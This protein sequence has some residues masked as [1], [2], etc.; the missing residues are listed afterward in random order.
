MENNIR[1]FLKWPGN[2]YHL[3]N[4]IKKYLKEPDDNTVFVEPFLGSAAVFLNT[5]Y[6]QYHLNDN[7]PDLINLYL[8]LQREGDKFIKYCSKYFAAENNN[9]D[10]YYDLR[11]KFNVTSSERLKA[12]LF[13]YLNKHGYNG[14]CRYN[15]SGVYNVPFGSF[16]AVRLPAVAMQAFH[17]KS[18][19]VKTN[20]TCV[21]FRDCLDNIP[22]NSTVYCDPPYVPIS[23]SASF[24]KYSQIDFTLENQKELSEKIQSLQNQGI[25]SLISNHDLKYTR[26][27]YAGAKIISFDVKRYIS[28]KPDRKSVKELLAIYE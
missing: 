24:T 20:F 5:H 14:L 16:T 22:S 6:K 28:C 10:I 9:K 15:S 18:S 26:D 12:A 23:N 4:I 7:N 25:A 27:L 8:Y 1:P 11:M 21:D 17:H 3:V 2:K 13:L 19:S